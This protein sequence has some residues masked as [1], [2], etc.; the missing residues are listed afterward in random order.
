MGELIAQ[1]HITSIDWDPPKGFK[2][3]SWDEEGL[4]GHDPTWGRFWEIKYASNIQRSLLLDIQNRLY[5]KLK[6]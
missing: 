6:N 2:R 1:F 4:M 3:H 5:K